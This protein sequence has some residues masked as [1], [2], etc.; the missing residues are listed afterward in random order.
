MSVSD[1]LAVADSLKVE[2][3]DTCRQCSPLK[4]P[5]LP[6]WRLLLIATS[7]LA[8]KDRRAHTRVRQ[9]ITV[10]PPMVLS[11][12]R[13]PGR[14]GQGPAPVIVHVCLCACMHCISRS[15]HLTNGNRH[16]AQACAQRLHCG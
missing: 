16:L 7:P 15:A 8:V 10:L 12:N 6:G 9:C 13:G 14:A 3:V 2:C 4:R 5:T 11:G 1:G